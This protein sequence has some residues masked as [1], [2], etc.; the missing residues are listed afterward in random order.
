MEIVQGDMEYGCC[1]AQKVNM[2][3]LKKIIVC[4]FLLQPVVIV[5]QDVA[6]VLSKLEK[7]LAEKKITVSEILANESYMYLHSQTNFRDIIKK[8]AGTVKVNIV[9]A[10]EQG[11][12][13]TVKCHVTDALGKPFA[14]AL[15]YAYQTSAKGWYADTAAHILLNEGDYRYARLFGYVFTGRDGTF[16]IETIQPSG[17]PDSDLPAHIHIAMWKDDKYVDGVPGELLFEEDERLTAERKK[18]SVKEGFII[19]KNTGT[20]ASPVYEYYFKVN[21]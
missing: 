18:R 10:T 20:K 8:Y 15:V 3:T 6:G 21:Q 11:K 7:N 4:F 12:K 16:E 1:T 9:T 13:I 19:A 14:N 2:K 17:Y 5:A